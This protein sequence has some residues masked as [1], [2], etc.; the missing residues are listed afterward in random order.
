MSYTKEAVADT[1]NALP[2]SAPQVM[3]EPMSVDP[4]ARANR[5]AQSG[6]QNN[7]TDNKAEETKAPAETVTLSP[8]VAALARKER[9]FRQQQQALSE[10]EKAIEARAAK[11]A[12]YEAMEQKLAAKDYSGLEDSVNYEEYTQ[13]L[14]DK[15]AKA[16]PN[17]AELEKIK[18]EVESVKRA[19][20]EQLDKQYEAAVNQR[21]AAI[22][23]VYTSD[24]GFKSFEEKAKSA[25][26]QINLQD[27]VVH[28]LLDTFE[29]ESIE[30][31]PA[32]AA[33]EVHEALLERAKAYASL[34][35]QPQQV[36]QGAEKK[37]LP[38]LKQ[39]LKTLTNNVI[40]GDGLKKPVK[41]YRNMSQDERYA[42]AR[43]RAV[44]KLNSQRQG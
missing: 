9:Q 26:P 34:L 14:L 44:E 28:H 11:I 31:K 24:P 43:R 17:K 12:K 4:Y 23:E 6:Q 1:S 41:D 15:Q 18:A 36:E 30:L 22:G 37:Q 35:D 13:Y 32:D 8:Q 19:N 40:A 2:Q 39:G 25:F 10:K 20:K 33:K 42:E 7:S 29:H 21:K 38:P 5:A 3:R 16:D 27:V